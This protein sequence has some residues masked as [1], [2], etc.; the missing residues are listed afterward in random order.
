[1]LRCMVLTIKNTM[2]KDYKLSHRDKVTQTFDEIKVWNNKVK[3]LK[4]S[5]A[6]SPSFSAG[7]PGA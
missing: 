1:M 6:D 4:E 2:E 7:H 3:P 5:S